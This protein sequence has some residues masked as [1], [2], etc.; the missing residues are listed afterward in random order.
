MLFP[1]ARAPV[2]GY[3]YNF[4]ADVGESV[5]VLNLVLI[6]IVSKTFLDLVDIK[7]DSNLSDTCNRCR[8]MH[9]TPP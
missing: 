2:R 4:L 5:F 8:Q 6:T 7:V 1:A 9:L 3:S